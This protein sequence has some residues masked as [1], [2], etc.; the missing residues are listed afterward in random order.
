MR[1]AIRKH[2]RDFIAILF[3]ILVAAGT[4][5]YILSNQRFY[6]PAWVPGIGSDFYEVEAEF[7]TGQ[8]VVPGQGQTVNIAGVKV[9]DIGEVKLD[10]GVAVVELKIQDEHKPIYRDAKMLL[11]PK[12]GLKDMFVELDP[13][14]QA[15]GELPEGGR[16]TLA[17]TRPDVN[18]DEIL[19][20]LDGDTRAYLQILANAGG[21]AFTDD[22][23]KPYKQSYSADL[24]ETFKRFEPTNKYLAKFT[25]LLSERRQ[26]AERAIHSFSQLAQELGENDTQLAQ[27]VESSNANFQVFA[28]QEANL[29][30]ALQLLP[31]TLSTTQRTLGKVETLADELGPGFRALLPFARNLGPALR[32]TRP[33]L[34]A[35]TP[36]IRD[37]IRPFTRIARSPVRKLR[38]AAEELAPTTS[39]LVTS[40]RVINDLLDTLAYNPPGN[41]EGFLFWTAWANHNAPFVFN[42]QD[43]HGPI[44]R[45]NFLV[46][47]ASL[48]AVEALLPGLPQ[49]EVLF[50]L[51][52]APVSEEVCAQQETPALRNEK[53]ADDAKAARGGF[54]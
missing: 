28:E 36:I 49:L 1:R 16:I 7:E 52:N 17:Q 24:R 19:A 30:R 9:G 6:L 33:A 41:E 26:N 10:D 15:A 2:L 46:D 54:D 47:C 13:G 50:E 21:E 4:A 35:T 42:T 40:F 39:R 34:R 3:L 43:A 12:T 23:S 53:K 25:G 14:T 18:P 29:R 51:L 8:A 44:R 38:A 48:T 5:G 37:E 31:G 22:P 11:R 45:G 20:Q 32:D 27:L